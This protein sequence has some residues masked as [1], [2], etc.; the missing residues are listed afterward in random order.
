MKVNVPYDKEKDRTFYGGPSKQGVNAD[1]GNG[2]F[3]IMFP[4]DGHSPQHFVD[5][6]ELIKKIT[7]KIKIN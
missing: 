6:A 5:K 7:I 1:I 4:N 3:V 2:V